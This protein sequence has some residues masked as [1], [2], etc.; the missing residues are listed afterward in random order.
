[1]TLTRDNLIPYVRTRLGHGAVTVE[2]TD[3]HIQTC[4]QDAIDVV[5]TYL[6]MMGRKMLPAN[7]SG[8]YDMTALVPQIQEV[9]AVIGTRSTPS[10]N[11]GS[12][13]LFDPLLYLAGGPAGTAS[14]G[15]Y[16]QSLEMLR[17]SRRVYNAEVE[18]TTQ[19][20]EVSGESHLILYVRVP[21]LPSMAYGFDYLIGFTADDSAT[22]LRLLPPDLH[23]WFR[24][25]VVASARMILGHI[26]SKYQGFPS[27]DGSDLQ[28][29]GTDLTSSAE[30]ELQDL[31]DNIANMRQNIGIVV[32]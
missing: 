24:R 9:M 16:Q 22:G 17:T 21:G 26:R 1:M 19:R 18:F 6:P 14:V 15:A 25:Y 32:F 4:I 11:Y 27:P 30:N 31:R 20:E 28:L 10:G 13:D 2:L 5:N 23:S 3:A 12:L 8:R 29:D 7:T